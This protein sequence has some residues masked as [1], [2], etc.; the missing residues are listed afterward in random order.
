MSNGWGGF[1]GFHSLYSIPTAE[2]EAGSVNPSLSNHPVHRLRSQ[3]PGSYILPFITESTMLIKQK[4][5]A[6]KSEWGK[7]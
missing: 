7:S 1:V 3:S 2:N 6:V 5:K 4:K